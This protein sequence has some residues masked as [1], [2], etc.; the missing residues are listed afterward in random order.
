MAWSSPAFNLPGSR[1]HGAR[2][3]LRAQTREPEVAKLDLNDGAT[4][5]TSLVSGLCVPAVLFVAK[6]KSEGKQQILGIP[7]H[8][9]T[10]LNLVLR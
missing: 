8:Q 6:W 3:E 4:S 7:Q 10:P 9:G 1:L 2:H 5:H